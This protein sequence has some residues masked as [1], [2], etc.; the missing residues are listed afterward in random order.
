LVALSLRMARALKVYRTPIG[1]H[2]AYVAAPSQTAALKAW[3]TDRN[4]FARGAAELVTDPALTAAPLAAPGDVI[5]VMREAP[6]EE[7]VAPPAKGEKSTGRAAAPKKKAPPRP[8]RGRLERAEQAIETADAALSEEVRALTDQIAALEAQRR[9]VER[10]HDARR[11]RLQDARDK[12]EAAYDSA[13]EKWRR[14]AS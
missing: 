8:D 2:D 12:A 13:M 3:G 6:A 4:L 10:R 9:A 14:L 11:A 7:P 5:K 1:F